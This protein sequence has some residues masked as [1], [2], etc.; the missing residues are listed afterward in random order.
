MMP[1]QVSSWVLEET[2]WSGREWFR[3][4]SWGRR[5]YKTT[6]I[7]RGARTAVWTEGTAKE[8]PWYAHWG[9]RSRGRVWEILGVR[10]VLRRS[11]QTLET[12]ENQVA[13]LRSDTVGKR[14]P[15]Q[16]LEQGS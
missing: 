4:T 6:R 5:P 15:Q 9:H 7:V 2:E 10:T 1:G 11:G 12:A 8:W 13:E 3:G 14:E 16:V